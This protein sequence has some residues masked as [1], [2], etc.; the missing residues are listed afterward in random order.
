LEESILHLFLDSSPELLVNEWISREDFG[1]T[2]L[3]EILS[4][5]A[6]LRMNISLLSSESGPQPAATSLE[7]R[8]N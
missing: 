7:A 8:Q 3:G 5:L 1:A 6:Q 4:N 2:V